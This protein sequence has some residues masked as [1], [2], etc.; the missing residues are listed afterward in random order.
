[1]FYEAECSWRSGTGDPLQYP[2]VYF[3]MPDPIFKEDKME[4]EFQGVRFG[5]I[6][7]QKGFA[8]PERVIKALEIQVKEDLI[9]SKHRLL[10]VIL[11]DEGDMTPQQVQEVLNDLQTRNGSG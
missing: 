5:M 7:V 1:M 8:T 3:L 11:V 4:A 10:G 9:M 2:D 6:A